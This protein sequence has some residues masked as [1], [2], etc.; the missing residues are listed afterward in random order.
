MRA[1]GR[2]DDGIGESQLGLKLLDC[3]HLKN[4]KRKNLAAPLTIEIANG[5]QLLFPAGIVTTNSR[6]TSQNP[7][8]THCALLLKRR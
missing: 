3:F 4:S 2:A 8:T 6:V 1:E 7:K 5:G